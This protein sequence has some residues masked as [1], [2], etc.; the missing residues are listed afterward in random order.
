MPSSVVESARMC[1]MHCP[2]LGLYHGM[3]VT[4]LGAGVFFYFEDLDRG[5]SF[6]KR[7]IMDILST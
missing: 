2:S 4:A 6:S 3:I 1:F 7:W 5:A